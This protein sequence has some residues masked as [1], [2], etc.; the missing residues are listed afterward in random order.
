[1]KQPPASPVSR[2]PSLL[3][4]RTTL[5]GDPCEDDA[6]VIIAH[7]RILIPFLRLPPQSRLILD[8]RSHRA[9]ARQHLKHSTHILA[10]SPTSSSLT[11]VQA[12]DKRFSTS[13]PPRHVP[14]L[15]VCHRRDVQKLR[16]NFGGGRWNLL[17]LVVCS[18]DDEQ[19]T[20][21]DAGT[22]AFWDLARE[23]NLVTSSSPSSSSAT[24]Q[25][26][27]CSKEDRPLLLG[28]PAPA[29]IR[30]ANL[31]QEHPTAAQLR[32][33]DLG[34]GAGRDIAWLAYEHSHLH[35]A[36]R[37]SAEQHIRWL[38]SGIDNLRPALERAQILMQDFGL[39]APSSDQTSNVQEAFGQCEHLLWAEGTRDG[40][41]SALSGPGRG[42]KKNTAKLDASPVGPSTSSGKQPS[43]IPLDHSWHQSSHESLLERFESLRAFAAQCLPPSNPSPTR[44]DASTF[45]LLI[46]VRF[47]PRQLL[48]CLP[49]FSHVGTHVVISHFFHADTNIGE[50]LPP[51]LGKVRWDFENPPKE[52]RLKEGDV[53]GLRD[54]WSSFP[55]DGQDLSTLQEWDIVQQVIEP[56][57]DGRPVQSTILRRVQ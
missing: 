53:Q 31:F 25:E 51:T 49:A 28:Q 4:L 2:N 22:R 14:F 30:A 56:I 15:L 43:A 54:V 36:L 38:V 33:L 6:A 11:G 10:S 16:E 12:L 13:L 35:S 19:E 7:L 32:V 55:A 29:V 18:D 24:L 52:A 42:P 17:G 9:F 37:S 41:L 34:C 23:L 5:D 1:M 40:K 39:M 21:D 44:S 27:L 48:L 46:L 26:R 50:Q 8:L 47:L 57:E 45:D 3:T 20:D